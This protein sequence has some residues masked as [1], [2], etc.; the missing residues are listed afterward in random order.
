M[1]IIPIFIVTFNKLEVLKKS[2]ASYYKNIGTPFIRNEDLRLVT[3]N[4]KFSDDNN[5]GEQAYAAMLRSPHAHAILKNIDTS[6]TAS[7]PGVLLVLT[8]RDWQNKGLPPLQNNT[9]LLYTS[10]S[11]RDR[12]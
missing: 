9:C 8:G 6:V 5:I 3:G 10:P 4:G 12:G 2:I 1:K 11:P 7:M